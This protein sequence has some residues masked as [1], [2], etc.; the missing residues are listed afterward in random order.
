MRIRIIIRAARALILV[1]TLVRICS[2]IVP[3]TL[4][5][6]P[7][8]SV[9]LILVGAGAPVTP[10]P[11]TL[12]ARCRAHVWVRERR[13][14]ILSRPV[15]IVAVLLLLLSPTRPSF[16]RHCALETPHATS[17]YDMARTDGKPLILVEF[18]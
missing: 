15:P 16:C 9:I 5:R 8:R 10:L 14:L 6:S 18:L 11:A 4:S 2:L 17:Y 1:L 3:L 13:P 7:R 12:A